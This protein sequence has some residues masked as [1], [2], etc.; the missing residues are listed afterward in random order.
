[1]YDA[2]VGIVRMRSSSIV[3]AEAGRIALLLGL[4]HGCG[5]ASDPA[6][7]CRAMDLGEAAPATVTSAAHAPVFVVSSSP[8]PFVVFEWCPNG[9]D[10]TLQRK[11]LDDLAPGSKVM[12][13][14]RGNWVVAIDEDGSLYRY[15]VDRQ[16]ATLDQTVV[17]EDDAPIGRD[18]YTTPWWLVASLRDSDGV[19]VRNGDNELQYYW[20]DRR[21]ADFVADDDLKLVAIGERWIAGREDID[22]EHER[23]VLVEVV[24]PDDEQKA[25]RR[26]PIVVMEGRAFSRVE[27]TA[28]DARLV[29]TSGDAEDGETFVFDVRTGSLVD[30][31]VGAAVTGLRDLESVA[32]LRATSPDGSH[33]AYRTSTGAL[34]LRDLQSHSACLVRS[35]SAGDHRI[36]GFAADGTMYM[37]AELALSE[38]RVFA[39]DT[40]ERELVALDDTPGRGHHL[41]AAP[42]RRTDTGRPW[43]VGVSNG[44]YAALQE[45][46]GPAGLRMDDAVFLARD[47]RAAG[48]W[49]IETYRDDDDDRRLALRRFVPVFDGRSYAFATNGE[50]LPLLQGTTPVPSENLDEMQGSERPCL[51]AGAPGQWAYQCADGGAGSSFAAGLPPTEDPSNP[52]PRDDLPDPEL[53]EDDGGSTED[54]GGSDEGSSSD[55]G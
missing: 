13:T 19:L 25:S 40:R 5:Q 10:C 29:A 30:R 34:A 16:A 39:F 36:A 8:S 3:G 31:F 9:I 7:P 50:D 2:N 22:G 41:V 12:L 52:P 27:L 44:Q 42:A 35:A 32:G 48:L 38:S 11:S 24:D 37:Q 49:A 55:E 33:L 6:V 15:R 1:V 47:D 17:L 28:G 23:L 26:D 18:G 21:S 14:S 54:D 43:A 46:Q 45:N 51:S 20:P 53:P 4:L